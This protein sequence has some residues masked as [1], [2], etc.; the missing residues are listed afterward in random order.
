VAKISVCV[1]T[2]YIGEDF[3]L[4]RIPAS[5]M[6]VAK[7]RVIPLR[8]LTRAEETITIDRKTDIRR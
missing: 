6:Q 1:Y 2:V 5:P 8:I 3:N 7:Y 4:Q